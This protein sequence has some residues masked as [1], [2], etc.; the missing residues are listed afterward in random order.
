MAARNSFFASSAED[1]AM[2]ASN[3]P[4]WNALVARIEEDHGTRA[5][6][7]LIDVGCHRGGFL[8]QVARRWRLGR[9]SGIEPVVAARAAALDRLRAAGVAATLL[10]P[11]EWGRIPDG[12]V[13]LLTAQEVLYLVED[14]GSLMKEVA[15]VLR[16]GAAAYMTLGS[17]TGNPLWPHWR[18]ILT[19]MGLIVFDHSPMDVLRAGETAGLCPA[20][21]PLRTDGWIRYSPSTARF[22]VPDVATLME[23]HYR[24]KLLFAF[25]KPG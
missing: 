16:P 25:G 15:R 17:H 11:E 13:P 6:D 9:V 1:E 3:G 23:H 18:P 19:E 8:E 4:F 5:F 21:R 12:T 2:E 20:V 24:H 14:L 10:G 7:D 22:P